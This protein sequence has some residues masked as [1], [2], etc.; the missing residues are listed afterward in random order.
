[1][2]R[3]HRTIV[4]GLWHHVTHRGGAGAAIFPT[5]DDR[6]DFLDVLAHSDGRFGLQAHAVSLLEA[7]YHLLVFDATGQ[8]GR[9]MRHINGVYT[10]STNR[11]HGTEGAMFRGRYH[12]RVVHDDAWLLPVL[13]YIHMSPVSAGLA[14][15]PAAYPWA[16]HA[17]YLADDPA[18]WLHTESILARFPNP[19]G[20][21]A[22]VRAPVPDAERAVLAARS[23]AL[24]D[25]P[26][27]SP[28]AA[29]QVAL[30]DS[31][32]VR[33]GPHRHDR[34]HHRRRRGAL[35]RRQG[36]R[37]RP[38][39]RHGQ[40]RPQRRAACSPW[41]SPRTPSPTSARRFDL[42]AQSLASLASRQRKNLDG[43]SQLA[44][45]VAAI[46]AA[47]ESP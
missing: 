13:R 9:A 47:L 24:G 3:P 6:A 27:E 31:P 41:T 45:D 21:D 12:S 14:D 10:Q 26:P 30:P 28:V 15:D 33:P 18:P 23:S 2:A 4:A 1:M 32:P 35:R 34:P 38:P 42:S 22:Y 36:P 43:A 39:P 5:P 40:P 16:S 20:L 29:S 8:L 7:S 44:R 11:R 46:R 17:H 37:H 25:P 19:A